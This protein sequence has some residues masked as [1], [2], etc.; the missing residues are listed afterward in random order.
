[1]VPTRPSKGS[2]A[3]D[4]FEHEQAGVELDDLMPRLGL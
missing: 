4:D 2:D 1:M 3:N